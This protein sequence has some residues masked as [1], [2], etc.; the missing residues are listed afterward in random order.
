MTATRTPWSVTVLMALGTYVA[1][2]AMTTL[3]E[4]SQ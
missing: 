2:F 4:G 1:M 3:V